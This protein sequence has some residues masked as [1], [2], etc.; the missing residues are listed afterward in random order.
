MCCSVGPEETATP[1]WSVPD[2][3]TAA[4]DIQ[5]IVLEY[6]A[7]GPLNLW[8]QRIDNTPQLKERVS[9]TALCWPSLQ[10]IGKRHLVVIVVVLLF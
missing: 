4:L 5:C 7:G 9:Y 10:P 8:L 6:A 3:P 1:S 2:P